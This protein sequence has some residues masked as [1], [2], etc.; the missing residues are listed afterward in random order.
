MNTD[1]VIRRK[2]ERLQPGRQ[3]RGQ[4]DSNPRKKDGETD[5]RDSVKEGKDLS[6]QAWERRGEG[7]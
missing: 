4:K 6:K 5:E 2:M 3:T 7:E 1:Q